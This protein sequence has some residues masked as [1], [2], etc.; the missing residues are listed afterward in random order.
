MIEYRK[1]TINDIEDLLKV[2]IDFLYNANN[3][4]NEN[5]E[6]ILL[7]S[8]REFLSSSLLDGSFEQFLALDGTKIVATSSISYYYLPPNAM[9]PSGKVAYIGNMFTYPEYREQGIATTLFALSVE[10]ARN[11]N[12]KEICLDATDMGKPIYEKYGFK[13]NEDAMGYY[14]V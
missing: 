6:M 12:C 10:A 13:K 7:L 4:R 8:N 3:I 2:R 14:I 11:A 9:R 5:D 1:A